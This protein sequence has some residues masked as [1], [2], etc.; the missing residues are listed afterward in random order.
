[1][2][3]HVVFGLALLMLTAC[4]P[5]PELD[6]NSGD[7]PR[8]KAASAVADTKWI[9]VSFGVPGRETPV[10]AGPRITLAFDAQGRASGTGGCN[11]YGAQ[12]RVQGNTLSFDDVTHTLM[13]CQLPDISQQ[14]ERYLSALESAGKFELSGDRL[15]IWYDNG[16]GILNWS[17]SDASQ[18]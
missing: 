11:S 6:D 2:F 8:S 10:L 5:Q 1:M 15:A 4:A 7:A 13:A 17:K 12:Y 3:G 9:L 18:P 16:R 14:E